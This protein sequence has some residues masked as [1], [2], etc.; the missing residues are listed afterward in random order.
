VASAADSRPTGEPGRER[1]KRPRILAAAQAVFAEQGFDAARMDEVARRARVGKGTLYNYY[2]SKEDLLIHAVIA[3]MEEVRERIAT[4]V[5]PSPD[6]PIRSVEAVLRMLIVEA[7]P[8]LTRG[9]HSLYNQAWGVIARDP[10][11]RRRFFEANQAFYRERESDFEELIEAGARAGQFRSDLDPAEISL[12]VQALF[13]GLLRR[14]TFDPER[15]DPP[16]AF[17]ALLQ[18]LRGGLYQGPGSGPES[19]R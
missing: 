3:S 6:E 5:D 11:A 12:L 1:D 8:A 16:R 9:F 19:P 10:E 7:L 4:A 18:L 14:A 17:G 2:E 15:V 13:D